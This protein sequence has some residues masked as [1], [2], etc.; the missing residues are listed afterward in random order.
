MEIRES[1]AGARDSLHVSARLHDT[2]ALHRLVEQAE[3]SLITPSVARTLPAS[4]AAEAHRAIAAGGLR[5]RVVLDF[6][7]R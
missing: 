1:L 7:S 4:H 6:T 5:G 2:A 3:Q